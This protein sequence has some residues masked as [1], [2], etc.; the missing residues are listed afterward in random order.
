M[1]NGINIFEDLYNQKINYIVWK[2]TNLIEKF[3]KGEENLDI[4]IH[5]EHHENFKILLKK[6]NW[7]EVKSTSNNF[8]QIKHYL[9]LIMT[10]FYIFTHI[11]N[12]TQVIPF[13]KIMI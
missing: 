1:K 4:F 5:K 9:F 13:L 3:F 2:N 12:F 11:T 10:K 8:D 6:N 7:I